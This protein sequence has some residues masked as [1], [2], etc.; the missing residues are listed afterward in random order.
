MAPPSL[1][2]ICIRKCIRHASMIHDLGDLPFHVAKPILR[3]LDNAE[4]LREIELNSPQYLDETQEIW[5]KLIARDFPNWHKKNYVPKNPHSWWRVYAKYKKENDA[6]LAAAQDKL[7]NAFSKLKAHK[8]ARTTG[9]IQTKDLSRLPKVK[10]NRVAGPGRGTGGKAAND[11][12]TW[13]G[14]SR[15]KLTDGASFLKKARREAKEIAMRRQLST[16]TGQLKVR[17]GQI[18]K[19]PEALVQQYRIQKQDAL[20]IRAPKKQMSERQLAEEAERRDREAR[21][22]KIKNLKGAQPAQMVS[23]SEDDGYEDDNDDG[24]QGY[25]GLGDFLGLEDEGEDLF[26]ENEEGNVSEPAR[27]SKPAPKQNSTPTTYHSDSSSAAPKQR[28]GLISNARKPGSGLLSAKP[29]PRKLVVHSPP[30]ST[31]QSPQPRQQ[32]SPPPKPRPSVH[33][34]PPPA[35]ARSLPASSQHSPPLRA[36]NSPPL[37]PQQSPSSRP[38][39]RKAPVDIFMRQNIPKKPK[40]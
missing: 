36:Q 21:L 5:K 20:R 38:M 35:A 13:G 24:E 18:V 27:P 6:E 9:E 33:A 40:K 10:D 2:D 22:L 25:G 11:H 15:T 14:G 17:E 19:A 8:E 34:S 32:T 28:T 29:A 4:Q 3:K 1:V 7:K 37:G 23:D 30:T 26:S 12:L 16:P 31:T 39:K